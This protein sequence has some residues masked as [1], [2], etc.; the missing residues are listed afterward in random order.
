MLGDRTFD[1]RFEPVLV[2]EPSA[3]ETIEILHGLKDRYE[4]FHH[5]RISDE[6]IVAAVELADRYID[7]RFRPSKAIDLIDRASARVRLSAEAKG[8]RTRGRPRRQLEPDVTAEHVAASSHGRR[9]FRLVRRL[10]E[11][12][13]DATPIAGC[14]PVRSISM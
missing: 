14:S 5:V 8:E 6:G 1:R 3:E 11:R 9:A 7:G 2:H 12:A 13:P 4:R 10:V